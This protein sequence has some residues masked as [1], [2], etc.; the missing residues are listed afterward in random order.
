MADFG[1]IQHIPSKATE[2][3]GKQGWE[4][5]IPLFSPGD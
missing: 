3:T 2:V 4:V 5:V 1:C